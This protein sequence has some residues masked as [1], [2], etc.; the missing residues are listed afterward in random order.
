[1][2]QKFAIRSTNG[3]TEQENKPKRRKNEQAKTE[4]IRY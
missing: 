4:A 1:M 3:M 2:F